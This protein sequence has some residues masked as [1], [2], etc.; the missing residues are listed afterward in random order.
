MERLQGLERRN[1][2]GRTACK[3]FYVDLT[4]TLRVYLARRVGVRALEQ[5]TPEVLVA[6]RRRPEVQEV[7]LRRLQTVL[8]QA[9]LVKFADAEPSPEESRSILQDAQGVVDALEAAQRRVE[10]AS[11]DEE[12][13]SA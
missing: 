9:D 1:P 8:K 12:S 13:A 3:A 4:E 7:V 11:V 6:L 2:T 5:T 10:S